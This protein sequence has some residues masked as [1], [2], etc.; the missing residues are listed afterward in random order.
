M[1]KEEYEEIKRLAIFSRRFLCNDLEL[2]KS[3][4]L[5]QVI[6]NEIKKIAQKNL[7]F[8]MPASIAN[9]G[10]KELPR[11]SIVLSSYVSRDLGVK[12][13]EPVI[14]HEFGHACS[15]VK[16]QN[17]AIDGE[18]LQKAKRATVWLDEA[19]LRC[20][21]DLVP[22]EAYY[23]FWESIGETRE[24]ASCLK[25]LA[26]LNQ[27]Q[28]IDRPCKNICPGHY[29]EE[30]VGIAFSLLTG[31]LEGKVESVFPNTCDH[32]R[33]AQHPMVAD[34]VECLTQN[35]QHFREKLKRTYACN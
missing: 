15:M 24:L 12:A 11:G 7:P 31:D 27:K 3:N 19:K 34:V 22:P 9:Q 18:S 28:A 5:I 16:M 23:D 6:P 17:A 21:A 29:L 33:D 1:D 13:L 26:V 25:D 32:T 2:D 35:S 14:L 8:R 30:S 20:K 4:V 10:A